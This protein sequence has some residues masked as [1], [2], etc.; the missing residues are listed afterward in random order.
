MHFEGSVQISASRDKVWAFLIDP[1]KV[2]SCGPGVEGKPGS[3]DSSVAS[4]VSPP[5]PRF[6]G[7]RV[8]L[9]TRDPNFR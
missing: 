1:D 9:V 8:A 3:Q 4:G 6:D 7:T 5:R 2:G